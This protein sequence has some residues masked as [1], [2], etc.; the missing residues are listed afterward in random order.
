MCEPIY[1]NAGC[2]RPTPEFLAALRD[3]PRK[4]GALLMFDEVLA[5]FRMGPGGAQEYLGVTPDLC[6]LGKAV[7]GGYPLSVFGGRREIMER[8]MPT[9]DCQHS[10]TYN[11]HPTSVAAA[12]AALTIYGEPGFYDHIRSVGAK[13]FA[14]MNELFAKYDVPGRVEGLGARFGIYFGDVGG[15]QN[16]RDVVHHDRAM[17]LQ[18]IRAAI[19]HGVYFHDY[20]GGPCHHGFCAAMTLADVDDALRRLDGAVASYSRRTCYVRNGALTSTRIA[21]MRIGILQLWQET[22]TFNPLPTTRRD[23]EAFGLLRGAEIV[24]QLAA[25]NEPGGFI[26]SLR[27]WPEHPEIVG[28][29]RLPAWPSGRMT[30]ETFDWILAEI[31]AAFDRA[32]KLDGV[33]FALHGALA[34]DEHPDVEGEVLAAVRARI[35]PSTPLVATFDL[36]ANITHLMVRNADALVGFHTAPHVDVLETGIRGAAVLRRILV[37][38]VRPTTAFIKM[39]LVVPAERANTQDPK[40]VSFAFRK[41]VESLEAWPEVLTASLA[42]VQPWLDVPELGSAVLVTTTGDVEMAECE[43]AALAADVWARRMEYIPELVSVADGVRAAHDCRKGLTVLSDA[44][45]ATT[46]GA[47]GDS[48]WCLRELLKYDW[49]RGGALVT[50][51]APEIVRQAEALGEGREAGR[52]VRRRARCAEQ[53][54]DRTF[55]RGRAAVPRKVRL[56]WAFGNELADRH[57]KGRGAARRRRADHLYR[58]KRTAFCT[59]AVSRGRHRSV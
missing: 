2:I 40:S 47:P 22:N 17:M 39:P 33:L 43:A 11:G 41:R 54:A 42:T 14:G 56:E 24:E 13:L 4:H 58:A 9:G 30:A 28:L 38:G 27:A 7:G 19:E 57:G 48:T 55:D 29:V 35:G 12:I 34:A 8:L 3:E 1:F 23:F 44:A 31:T 46:S 51:V 16:Y 10:G 18:F 6:T 50:L 15:L 21:R 37:E 49:P 59:G 36:H 26:Q 32:G 5:A 53:Q 20:G 25:T 45:D 52:A